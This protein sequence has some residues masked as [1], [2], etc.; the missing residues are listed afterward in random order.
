MKVYFVLGRKNAKYFKT[1][2]IF[3]GSAY[4]KVIG[5]M[6][7]QAVYILIIFIIMK[8]KS[9]KTEPEDINAPCAAPKYIYR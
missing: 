5:N 3:L 1:K 9:E 8:N 6:Q 2:S 4:R 7:H